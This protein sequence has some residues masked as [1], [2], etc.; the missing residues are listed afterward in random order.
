MR[1]Y[2][3]TDINDRTYAGFQWEKGMVHKTSG[4]N[5]LCTSGWIHFYRD[6]LLAVLLNPI[7]AYY[8][9]CHLWIG[10]ARGKIKE[11]NGL[12]WGCS[13]FKMIRRIS[14]PK[15]TKIQRVAFGILCSLEVCDDPDYIEWANN[16]L[17]NIDRTRGAAEAMAKTIRIRNIVAKAACLAA[18]TMAEKESSL[19][20]WMSA[21]VVMNNKNIDLIKIA[22][23]ATKY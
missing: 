18:V 20:A 13:E 21:R 12:K 17:K 11:D 1:A 23:K 16:W 2:K 15:I 19:V 3:I 14:I 8:N 9:P 5:E 22:K 10:K 4:E 6:K 7:H